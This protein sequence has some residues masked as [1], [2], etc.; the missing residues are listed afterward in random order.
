[1]VRKR[2]RIWRTINLGGELPRKGRKRKPGLGGGTVKKKVTRN[3]QL[4]GVSTNRS[5]KGQ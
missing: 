2:K 4:R 5:F 1:L 3:R